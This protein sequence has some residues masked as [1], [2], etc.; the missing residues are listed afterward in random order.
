MNNITKTCPCNMEIFSPVKIENFII[1][2]LIF[3]PNI[4]AENI[5]CGY[6]LEAVLGS[7]HNLYFETKIK[8]KIAIPLHTLCYIKVGFKGVYIKRT[9]F[10][11]ETA[12]CI[13]DCLL[14]IF[15]FIYQTFFS[16][17]TQLSLK[18]IVLINVQMPTIV[19]ILT[20]ISKINYQLLRFEPEFS[21][22]FDY[23]SIYEQLKFHAQLI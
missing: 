4:F 21:T 14:S 8:K 22:N 16:C 5:D 2:I 13:Y 19:G 11:D 10:R 12:R 15:R 7:A 9:Y 18:F 6:T 3:L 1:I 23:F 17:S 20:Y